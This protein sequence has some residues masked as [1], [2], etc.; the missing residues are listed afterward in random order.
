[1]DCGSP[2]PLSGGQPAGRRAFF[3]DRHTKKPRLCASRECFSPTRRLRRQQ[4]CLGKA[5][6]GC[7][8]PC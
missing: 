8:S 5:A 4:G 2:L 1:M 7:R 3:D 6:A